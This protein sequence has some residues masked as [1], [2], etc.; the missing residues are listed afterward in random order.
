[1]VCQSTT[2]PRRYIPLSRTPP[3]SN[4]TCPERIR[5]TICATIRHSIR[6]QKFR[7][8]FL[9]VPAT[10]LNGPRGSENRRF[11]V[12]NGPPRLLNTGGRRW[13]MRMAEQADRGENEVIW[14]NNTKSTCTLGKDESRMHGYLEWPARIQPNRLVYQARSLQAGQ[15]L[16]ACPTAAGRVRPRTRWHR[17]HRGSMVASDVNGGQRRHPY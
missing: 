11:W 2:A 13:G 6:I 9:E 12:H 14:R 4:H 15:R 16:P 5:A 7:Q 3:S 8:V 10:Y 1:M 17:G